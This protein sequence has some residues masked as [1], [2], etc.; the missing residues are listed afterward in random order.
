MV[1]CVEKNTIKT[2]EILYLHFVLSQDKAI[3]NSLDDD[4]NENYYKFLKSKVWIAKNKE[5]GRY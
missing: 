3:S 4:Y 5:N 1:M 2:F